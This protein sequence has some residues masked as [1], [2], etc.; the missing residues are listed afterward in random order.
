MKKV[1]QSPDL[2]ISAK[3]VIFVDYKAHKKE[4]GPPFFLS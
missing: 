4:A 2:L 3:T 1:W